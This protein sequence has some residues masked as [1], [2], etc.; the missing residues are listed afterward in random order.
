MVSV[1]QR[2][3]PTP[4]RPRQPQTTQAPEDDA[5]RT[6]L[7]PRPV[8]QAVV[9]RG[10]L[11]LAEALGFGSRKTGLS[12]N[13][14]VA[15]AMPV[16]ELLGVLRTGAVEMDADQLHDHLLRRLGAFEGDALAAG[17]AASD[18]AD[19]HYALAATCDDIA[20]NLPG[21]DPA[22]WKTNSLSVHYF[23]DPNP[24]V[25]FY[26]RLHR[27]SKMPDRHAATL[28]LY[29]VCLAVG[30]EG[31]YRKASGGAAAL[32]KLRRDLYQ[33]YRG[34]LPRAA[35]GM[36]LRWLPVI[37]RG[38]R[39]HKLAPLWVITGVGASMVVMLYAVLAWT[40]SREAQAAQS[41]MLNLHDLSDPIAIERVSL[42]DVPKEPEVVVYEAPPTG[43]LARVRA[44]LD[45]EI[46]AGF[47]TVSEEG[48]Y[49]AI[50]LGAALQFGA[51]AATI[52][53]ESP[54]I[55]R[56]AAVL[57]AEPGAITVEGHSDNIPLSGRGRY[58]TNED[59]SAA[60]A[61][62]VRDL[63]AQYMSDAGRMTVSG[64]GAAKPLNRANTPA[65]RLQNRRVD[66]L[67]LKEQRL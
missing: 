8:R 13:P 24:G 58:K 23:G 30:F 42:P 61:A 50:R 60:R 25:G 29:F 16:L 21:A 10:Q 11:P 37:L 41:T 17:L 57:E 7:G 28:E 65:A 64:V 31:Q 14:A 3:K 1:P 43:Q 56:I 49:I 63:L 38:T 34:V 54:I 59:L 5:E 33:T 18:V 20:Q 47:T 4:A 51:G 15:A 27:L 62:T 12:S 48:D 45:P 2:R 66:I 44:Q 36:S 9:A 19:A 22:Y 67:L 26:T 6:I 32:M 53:A 55:T 35:P 40:L 46:K 39:R 52:K